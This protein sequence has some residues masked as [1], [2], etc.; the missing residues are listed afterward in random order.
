MYQK[1]EAV[2][3]L[4]PGDNIF[5]INTQWYNQNALVIQGPGAG[6]EVTAAGVHSD[7]YWLVQNI[8]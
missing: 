4:T 1:S 2:A 7:L 5:V 8:T 3:N 6:K